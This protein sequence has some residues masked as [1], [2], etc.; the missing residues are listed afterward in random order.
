MRTAAILL[1]LTA[2][3][4]AYQVTFP[5]KTQG[6]T[7]SGAQKLTWDRV[8]T[9]ALNFSVILVNQDKSILSGPESLAALVDGT[10]GSTNVNPPSGGWP[11]GDGFQV[12][13]V[14][15]EMEQST[16]Y[17]QSNQFNITTGTGSSS[18]TT[19]PTTSSV[20]KGTG[21]TGTLGGAT[22]TGADSTDSSLNPSETGA[23]NGALA[24]LDS[25]KGVFAI[26]GLLSTLLL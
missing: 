19:K 6:W 1:S 11:L 14:K 7:N 25:H 12:N 23:S 18:S 17:A 20:I 16:I 22:G 4:F 21:S 5:T 15:S 26:A 2:S 13:L 8:N 9:D 24:T 3:A 10:M